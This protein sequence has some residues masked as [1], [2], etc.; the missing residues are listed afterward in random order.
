MLAAVNAA[1]SQARNCGATAY[2][3]APSVR[4]SDKLFVATSAHSTDMATRNYFAHTSP[5]GQKF[6]DRAALA[7]YS[8]AY[9][10]NIAAGR[11]GIASVMDGW[12]KSEG[13]CKNIMNP[14][15][16][17]VAVACV[18]SSTSQYRTYWT[19]VLGKS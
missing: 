2:A 14:V 3:A 13:H 5:E 12:I 11:L 6:S 1:R 9:G 15:V 18:G 10:E 7:G 19:M 16:N 17:D 8:F 4:W